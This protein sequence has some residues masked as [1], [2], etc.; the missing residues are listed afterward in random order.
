MRIYDMINIAFL[1]MREMMDYC[2][3]ANETT[4]EEEKL[5]SDLIPYIKIN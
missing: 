3:H 2:I 5:D 4:T 1:V